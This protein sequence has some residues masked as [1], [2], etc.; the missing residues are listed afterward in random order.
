MVTVWKEVIQP[1]RSILA[2][3][4]SNS[5]SLTPLAFPPS[6]LAIIYLELILKTL[7]DSPC[8]LLCSKENNLNF[9]FLSA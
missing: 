3:D 9:S 6:F 8:N 1:I 4:K 7:S 2:P 5:A